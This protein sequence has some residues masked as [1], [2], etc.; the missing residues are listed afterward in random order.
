MKKKK[1][2]TVRF[3]CTEEEFNTLTELSKPYKGL[4]D[5]MRKKLF[6][7]GGGI[8]NTV[9]FIQL[10]NG[11]FTEIRKS[12]NNINQFAKY[13]NQRSGIDNEKVMIEYNS[14]WKGYNEQIKELSICFRKVL[15][16]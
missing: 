1:T 2:I 8:T 4:S 16:L 9:Q 10:I 6:E 5:F 15:K 13:A 14:L 11:I 7:K 3:R 12:G